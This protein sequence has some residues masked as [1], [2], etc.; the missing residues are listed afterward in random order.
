MGVDPWD[1]RAW[2]LQEKLMSTRLIS[3]SKDELQFYCKSAAVCQCQRDPSHLISTDYIT[4]L[5]HLE[6]P[7]DAYWVWHRIVDE[8]SGRSLTF[9]RDKLAA[10][11]AVASRIQDITGSEYVAGLWEEN[12]I[13]DLC[14]DIFWHRD[15]LGNWM[16]GD[17]QPERFVSS[18]YC[19]PTFSWASVDVGV[20]YKNITR[21]SSRWISHVT[22]LGISRSVSGENPFGQVDKCCS[23][24]IL[25]PILPAVLNNPPDPQIGMFNEFERDEFALCIGSI[26]RHPDLM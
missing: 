17:L 11:S 5:R 6:S 1:R 3:F 20:I 14:W 9:P 12:I 18:Q 19:A 16:H 13:A 21:D 23:L 26:T 4:I 2:T 7:T 22:V 24:T 25:G 8:Y 15:A 10:I